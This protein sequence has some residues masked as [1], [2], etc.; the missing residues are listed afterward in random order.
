VT[1][2]PFH[3]RS[4]AVVLGALTL[5]A[6]V[7]QSLSPLLKRWFPKLFPNRKG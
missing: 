7:G 2:P 6:A 3:Q 4:V 5:L 1:K